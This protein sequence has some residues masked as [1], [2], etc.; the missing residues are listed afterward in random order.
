M[1]PSLQTSNNTTKP[2]IDENQ[3]VDMFPPHLMW[4]L[5]L[6][7]D[8]TAHGSAEMQADHS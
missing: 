3:V 8:S 5:L 7:H 6:S 2:F 4:V 1:S